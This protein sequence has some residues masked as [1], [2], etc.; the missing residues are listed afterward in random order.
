[1]Q[2]LAAGEG[3]AWVSTAGATSADGLPAPSCGELLSGSADPDVLIA[4][5]LQLPGPAG[6]G[7][8]AM[9]DAIRQVL[10]QRDF[11]AG[12]YAV[13]YRSCDDSTAQ[14]GYFESRTCAANANAYARAEELVAVIGTFNSACAQ[15]EVPI[16]N[17]APGG[18]LAM[19]SPLHPAWRRP[20]GLSRGRVVDR[21]VEIP[22][23]LIR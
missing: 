12:R 15:V 4:S 18:P 14:A 10:E 21:V 2:G 17:R 16:L 1:V 20:S 19:I 7:P 22:R 11:R 8:R 3:A 9:A 13:G 23:R 5:D 6:K